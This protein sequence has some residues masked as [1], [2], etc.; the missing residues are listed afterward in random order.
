MGSTTRTTKVGAPPPPLPPATASPAHR[1]GA[2]A[3][4]PKGGGSA[5]GRPPEEPTTSSQARAWART[6]PGWVRLAS[7]TLAVVIA[8]TT[9]AAIVVTAT[10]AHAAHA[11]RVNTAQALI[12]SQTIITSLSAADTAAAESFLAGAD[13]AALDSTYEVQIAQANASLAHAAQQAGGDAQAAGPL[14]KLSSGIPIY[15]GLIATAQANQRATHPVATAY[16][17]EANN[18]MQVFLLGAAHDLYDV[19]QRRIAADYRS[20]TNPWPYALVLVLFGLTLVGLVVLQW[21]LSSRFHRT[22][23]VGVAVATVLVVGAGIWFGVAL[24]GE[25]RQ[26]DLAQQQ[27]SNPIAAFTQA[28]I[29]GQRQRSDDELALV[30][31]DAVPSYQDDYATTTRQLSS[32]LATPYPAG[33]VYQPLR[34][35]QA[36]LPGLAGIHG[37]I[38]SADAGGHLENA[39]ALAAGRGATRLPA[40]SNRFDGRLGH[41]VEVTRENF[42]AR[43]AAAQNDL[44]GI[45]LGLAALGILAVA[46]V[47]WG[48]Q[49][50]IE[51]YR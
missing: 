28:R 25:S 9:L 19:A 48:S 44:V 23:N 20:A 46:L 15:T 45:Y 49:Q 38:R 22:F 36:E 24:R 47:L 14:Q 3:P 39:N 41:A 30:T 32:L 29:L 8:V 51:E 12:D 11:A 17:S 37:S 10:R 31:R 13:R 18:F 6:T 33:L 4:G 16:L 1:R 35:A 34:D 50:R 27:G 2:P 5:P 21:R 26:L 43:T 7:A 40:L 42:A